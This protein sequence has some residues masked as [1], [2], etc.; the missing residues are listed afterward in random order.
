MAKT[1]L[2]VSVDEEVAKKIKNDPSLSQTDVFNQGWEEAKKQE[3]GDLERFQEQLEELQE[4]KEELESQ[5][6]NVEIQI[7]EVRENIEQLQEAQSGKVTAMVGV[8]REMFKQGYDYNARKRENTIPNSVI[9]VRGEMEE[10]TGELILPDDIKACYEDVV[11]E[12]DEFDSAKVDS[13]VQNN[14]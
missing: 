4:E 2:S 1:T 13:W 9:G 12:M 6:S 11:K 14:M 8:Q 5:L 10:E 3:K 7:E